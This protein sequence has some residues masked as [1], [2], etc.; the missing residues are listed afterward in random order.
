MLRNLNSKFAERVF[1]DSS[2]RVEFLNDVGGLVT[3]SEFE[4]SE[5]VAAV[6]SETQ[7]LDLGFI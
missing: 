2:L 3:A 5:G 4:W 6:S 7:T 1:E